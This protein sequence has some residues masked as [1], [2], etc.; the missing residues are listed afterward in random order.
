MNG[1]DSPPS[2]VD[3]PRP[4]SGPG[5]QVARALRIFRVFGTS[6]SLRRI[7]NPLVASIIPVTNAFVILF[8]V[9]GFGP[10][11]ARRARSH[12]GPTVF[13]RLCSTAPRRNRNGPQRRTAQHSSASVRV[14]GFG[15][16]PRRAN[17]QRRTHTAAG[18]GLKRFRS[19][20]RLEIGRAD[21]AR[22]HC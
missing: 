10:P 5:V 20:P 3:P 4:G 11:S 17:G 15:P 22:Q 12:R 21:C 7:I 6:P 18:R 16:S 8:V 1:P 13:G 2:G 9:I 19:P 14:I